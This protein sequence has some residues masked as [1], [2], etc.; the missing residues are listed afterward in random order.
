[1]QMT[2]GAEQYIKNIEKAYE[3]LSSYV[4]WDKKNKKQVLTYSVP[5][6][7]KIC[8]LNDREM[9]EVIRRIVNKAA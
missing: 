3:L 5:Y 2:Y 8:K 4:V 1:M 7:K 9:G 6:V